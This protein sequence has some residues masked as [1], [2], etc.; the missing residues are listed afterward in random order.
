M[1]IDA[2][3][4]PLGRLSRY[5]DDELLANGVYRVTCALGT[6]LPPLVPGF[7]RMAE[8]LSGRRE[9]TDVSPRVFVTNRTV[10]F[11]EMEYALPRAADRK[12]TRLNSSHW[13]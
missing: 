13:E 7:S 12:S 11:R 8:K 3:R 5:V 2:Q 6:A 1:P 10:R 4:A 9:F